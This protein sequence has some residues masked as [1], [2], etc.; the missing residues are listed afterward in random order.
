MTV[1]LLPDSDKA[2]I[3]AIAAHDEDA[4][5]TGATR[6]RPWDAVLGFS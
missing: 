4:I 2:L 1:A 3:R 6:L 5:A